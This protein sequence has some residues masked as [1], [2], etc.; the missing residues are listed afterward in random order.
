MKSVCSHFT[1]ISVIIEHSYFL[2]I[3]ECADSA[4]YVEVLFDIHVISKVN[5][6]SL[7]SWNR[8]EVNK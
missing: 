6:S 1:S 2:Y 3:R 8:K 7:K 4:S 5:T